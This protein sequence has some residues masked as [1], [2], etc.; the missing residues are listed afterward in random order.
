MR[1]I[2]KQQSSNTNEQDL[3]IAIVQYRATST[4]MQEK[5]SFFPSLIWRSSITI[6]SERPIYLL[7]TTLFLEASFTL[8]TASH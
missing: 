6:V 8:S 2:H 4:S 3:I 5:I 7:P 1:V